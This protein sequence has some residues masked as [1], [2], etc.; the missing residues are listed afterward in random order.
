V[1]P[2]L[3]EQYAFDDE[4]SS[5]Q[6]PPFKHCISAHSKLTP[7]IAPPPPPPASTY[8]KIKILNYILRFTIIK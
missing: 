8:K 6:V 3:H 2:G 5:L 1:K 7:P 4:L